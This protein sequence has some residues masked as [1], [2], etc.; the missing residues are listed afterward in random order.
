MVSAISIE[1][2]TDWP[3][4][5]TENSSLLKPDGSLN[6]PG[7]AKTW[8]DAAVTWLEHEPRGESDRY[9]LAALD[10]APDTPLPEITAE[11]IRKSL[12]GHKA[13][14]WNRKKNIIMAILR[15]AHEHGMVESI[16]KLKSMPTEE[17]RILWLTAQEWARLDAELPRHLKPLARFAVATG[18]RRHNALE[19]AWREV[20][21]RRRVAWIHPDEAKARKP[22][23]VPLNDEAMV[24][25]E[26]QR[27]I[28]PTWVFPYRKNRRI[29][30]ENAGPMNEIGEAFGRACVRAGIHLVQKRLKG[31]D[32]KRAL[33]TRSAFVWHGLRH[34]WASWHVMNGTPLEVLQKLG[35]WASLDMVQKYAHLAP[36]H[37]ATY[38]N[39]AKP[40]SMEAE[41]I[42]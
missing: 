41:E 40:Y 18:L 14:T 24:V 8:A 37:V 22:I 23:S 17:G 38:A 28:S 20:D 12:A 9:T 29:A 7:T 35:G 25:L 21:M 3:V 42:A 16:P 27:G 34:T 32:G 19:L 1:R 11:R 2:T 39:N 15:L 36:G 10:L 5:F 6:A 31:R 4:T 33:V 30:W 26:G 13:A